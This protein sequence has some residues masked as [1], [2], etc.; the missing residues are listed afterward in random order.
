MKKKKLT[1]EERELYAARYQKA[2]RLNDPE[3]REKIRV[4]N[5]RLQKAKSYDLIEVQKRRLYRRR[6]NKARYLK[7]KKYR[8]KQYNKPI[9]YL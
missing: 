9:Q 8:K 4:Y 5:R 6:Y 2:K 7:N 3:W 1:K